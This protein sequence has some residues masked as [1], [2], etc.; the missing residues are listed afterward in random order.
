MAYEVVSLYPAN[1]QTQ[2]TLPVC[3]TPSPHPRSAAHHRHPITNNFIRGPPPTHTD[4]STSNGHLNQ[5]YGFDTPNIPCPLYN[6]NR[7]SNRNPRSCCTQSTYTF[8]LRGNYSPMYR[9]QCS[10]QEK[11]S[12]WQHI[13]HWAF[14]NTTLPR[15]NGERASFFTTNGNP[16]LT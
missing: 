5:S 6:H 3:T 11:H 4:P 15:H 16:A 9:I 7:T 8:I 14:P 10:T 12:T 2:Q 13:P 1:S